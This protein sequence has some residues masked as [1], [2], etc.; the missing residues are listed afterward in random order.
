MR[1]RNSS[2]KGP[3]THAAEQSPYCV[4]LHIEKYPQECRYDVFPFPTFA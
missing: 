1:A 4:S 2:H 3:T